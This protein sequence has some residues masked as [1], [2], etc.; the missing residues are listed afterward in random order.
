MNRLPK[1]YN[2]GY[3]LVELIVVIA[4]AGSVLVTI[5][6]SLL[7]ALKINLRARHST[8]AYQSA[9]Q[10]MEIIRNTPFA[11]LTNQTSGS[12]LGTVSTL[13]QLPSG[14]GTLT[15]Q[16]YQSNNKIK[17]IVVIISWQEKT[18]SKQVTQ[19]TLRAEGG[20]GQ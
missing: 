6:L 13:Q 15:I 8:F 19:S 3:S 5:Y 1:K 9:E 12:F 17:E 4:I 20:I 14:T 10:E 2:R 18:Q 16:D 11:N 7:Y